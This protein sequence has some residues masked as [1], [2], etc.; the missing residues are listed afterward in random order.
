MSQQDP[1]TLYPGSISIQT[2]L[3]H[4]QGTGLEELAPQASPA[5]ECERWCCSNASVMCV[6]LGQSTCT[7]SEHK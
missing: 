6:F 4:E 7:N 3:S 5:V 2:A 1:P